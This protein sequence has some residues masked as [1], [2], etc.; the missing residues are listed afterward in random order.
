MGPRTLPASS[1]GAG[2]LAPGAGTLAPGAGSWAVAAGTGSS[3]VAAGTGSGAVA[4]TAGA[5][6]GCT[7]DSTENK[8]RRKGRKAKKVAAR[9]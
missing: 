1:A 2:T 9:V 6:F 8:W 7:F 3:A 4:A 5:S